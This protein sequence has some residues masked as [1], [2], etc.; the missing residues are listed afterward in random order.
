MRCRGFSLIELMITIAVMAVLLAIG[1][2]SF[3]GSMRSNRVATGTNELTASIAL[4]R[5]EA[6]RSPGGAALCPSEDGSTCLPDDSP[7]NNGWIVWIDGDGNGLLNG[8]NDRVLR[9]VEGTA[10]LDIEASTKQSILKF[11]PR[12]RAVTPMVFTLASEV[13]PAG[14]EL[15]RKLTLTATGQVRMERGECE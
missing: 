13:C 11:D 6:I 8:V 5:S 14:H 3:Q 1:L 4:A 12:G 15:V 10:G 7:W 2:P 9:Y